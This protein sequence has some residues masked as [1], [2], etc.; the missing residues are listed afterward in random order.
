MGAYALLPQ[1]REEAMA[2]LCKLP[3]KPDPLTLAALLRLTSVPA[4]LWRLMTVSVSSSSSH[5]IQVSA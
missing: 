1:H 5:W 3:R 4:S 2:R